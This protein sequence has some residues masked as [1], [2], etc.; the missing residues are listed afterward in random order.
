MKPDVTPSKSTKSHR[1]AAGLSILWGIQRDMGSGSAA[2]GGM[3]VHEVEIENF[4]EGKNIVIVNFRCK[5]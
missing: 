4:S 2:T 5:S 3:I 1:M